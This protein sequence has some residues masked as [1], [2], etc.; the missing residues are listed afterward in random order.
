MQRFYVLF[1]FGLI[2]CTPKEFTSTVQLTED[3]DVFDLEVIGS[4]PESFYD[5]PDFDYPS[6]FAKVDGN[7]K[8]HYLDLNS[9]SKKVVVLL[10]G[11]PTWGYTYRKM[12]PSFIEGDFRVIVPDLIGFGKSDKLAN[13]EDYT[14]ERHV[15]WLKTL[16]FG[17]LKLDSIN[18]YVQG[19]GG[20]IGLRVVADV[21]ERFNTVVASNTGLPTGDEIPTEAFISWQ[22]ESQLYE[23][24]PVGGLV[25]AATYTQLSAREIAAFNAPYPTEEHKTGVRSAPLLVP[26]TPDHPASDANRKAWE[27][28]KEFNKPFLTLFSSL[29]PMARGWANS[30]R[31]NIPGARNQPHM[32]ISNAGHFI[33][34]DQGEDIALYMIAFIANSKQ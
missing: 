28:L 3:T 18:L 10:H 22:E 16:L 21:P 31:E 15:T 27:K 14:N 32:F 30:L 33:Q 19:W 20:I 6:S 17:N 13:L 12:I 11:E 29:D 1:I 5:L 23:H 4:S 8:M 26:T 25:Q 7:I 9:D 34:E 24:F 2:S